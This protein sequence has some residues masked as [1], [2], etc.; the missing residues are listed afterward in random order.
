[1]STVLRTA[2]CEL[3]NPRSNM[4]TMEEHLLPVVHR[5]QVYSSRQDRRKSSDVPNSWIWGL[6][7][8]NTSRKALCY[9]AKAFLFLT[10]LRMDRRNRKTTKWILQKKM[11]NEP[12]AADLDHD[13]SVSKSDFLIYK[14]KE[15]GKIDDKDI[16]MISDQFDQ[17]GLAKCGKI[18]LADIIGKL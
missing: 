18:T 9:I 8:L 16:A 15:I 17:L 13:A 1:M 11:D 10:D 12:L 2:S 7:L 4:S 14:L 6:W 3:M 5:D